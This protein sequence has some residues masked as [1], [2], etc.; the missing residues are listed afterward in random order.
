M[1]QSFVLWLLLFLV[2]SCRTNTKNP[3][4][5]IRNDSPAARI[6]TST[7]R[8]RKYLKETDLLAYIGTAGTVKP[9]RSIG[10]PFDTLD[11]DKLIAYDFEGNEE[12]YGSIVDKKK[13]FVP[14][15]LRQQY[16]K[17]KQTDQILALL[18]RKS[19]YGESSAFCF[20]PHFALL[21]FKDSKIVNKIDVC[22]GCN[23]LIADMKIPAENTHKAKNGDYYILQ[24]FSISGR[25]GIIDLCKELNFYYA[26]TKVS[27]Y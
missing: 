4:I 7:K 11:Y 14:V 19:T 10:A 5:S 12:P 8:E 25:K 2:F 27:R 20:E 24:G 17:Q 16:L 3:K 18:S 26:N 15:V 1:H 6:D 23:Y 9:K 13:K 21:F 22:L